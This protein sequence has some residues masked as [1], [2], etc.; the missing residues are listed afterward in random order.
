MRMHLTTGDDG[1][2]CSHGTHAPGRR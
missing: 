1:S 2:R